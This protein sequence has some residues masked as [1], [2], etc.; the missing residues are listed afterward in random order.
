MKNFH[1]KSWDHLVSYPV[2]AS[3]RDYVL[4]YKTVQIVTAYI[5][6]VL[7]FASAQLGK[8]PAAM[9]LLSLLDAK[10]DSLV[11]GSVDSVLESKYYA[12]GKELAAAYYAR[13]HSIVAAV[14]ARAAGVAKP[15]TERA[16]AVSSKVSTTV[17]DYKK[18]G[19]DTVSLQLK[20]VN[21]YALLTVDKVLPKG[22]AAKKTAESD[23]A[24][25]IEILND[26][27][28]RSKTL[29]LTKSSEVSDAVV[30][31]YNKEFD[32]AADKGYYAKVASASVNTG[33]TLLKN[34]NHEY[35][36][37]LKETLPE[38]VKSTVLAAESKTDAV[39][40]DTPLATD[41]PVLS[42]SA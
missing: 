17:E 6:A 34:I 9:S 11:L 1:S 38:T 37:P 16:Q 40:K 25:S 21:E 18:K 35:I 19:Q 15:Y 7:D 2:V 26:A 5:L 12:K 10:A 4:S 33:V 36:Q 32:A 24:E 3:T 29:L 30:L 22:K 8:S 23:F 20:R 13:V 27:F 42:A 31:T 41:T 39:L 14:Y 28:E